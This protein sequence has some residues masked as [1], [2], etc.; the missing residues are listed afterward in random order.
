[1][2]EKKKKAR[3]DAGREVSRERASADR[4]KV[5]VKA[6]KSAADLTAIIFWGFPR[7][8]VCA[9]RVKRRFDVP[10][11]AVRAAI[12]ISPAAAFSAEYSPSSVAPGTL[13]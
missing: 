4:A 9:D 6:D 5:A 12:S 3:I 10:S 2:G 7:A 13:R 8:R 1:M 11:V